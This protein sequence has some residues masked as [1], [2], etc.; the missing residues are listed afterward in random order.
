MSLSIDTAEVRSVLLAAGWQDVVPGSF[1]LGDLGFSTVDAEASVSAGEQPQPW[2]AGLGFEFEA[3]GGGL[4]AGPLTSVLAVSY[5]APKKQ[6]GSTFERVAEMF[7]GEIAVADG[8]EAVRFAYGPREFELWLDD[9]GQWAISRRD[10]E[11]G[12]RELLNRTGLYEREFQLLPSV[13]MGEIKGRFGRSAQGL[14]S[15]I[16]A[17]A[18]TEGDETAADLLGEPV[19]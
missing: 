2:P 10:H 12:G 5:A 8:S 4:M 17:Q 6:L 7:Q 9:L 14:G 11:T 3:R 1:R 13:V 19:E 15:Q 16:P 18:A